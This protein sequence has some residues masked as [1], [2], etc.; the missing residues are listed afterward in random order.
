MNVVSY[1]P[2]AR[3]L[4]PSAPILRVVRSAKHSFKCGHNN[5]DMLCWSAVMI[6]TTCVS[7]GSYFVWRS[8]C[9]AL[10]ECEATI[11]TDNK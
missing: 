6:G 10:G 2:I 1:E 9:I 7:C 4:A 3:V 5:A 11:H 8:W